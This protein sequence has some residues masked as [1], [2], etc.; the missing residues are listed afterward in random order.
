MNRYAIALALPLLFPVGTA[1]ADR[2]AAGGVGIDSV[3]SPGELKVTPDMWFYDQMMRQYK[4][5]KMAVRAKA[6]Y[7]SEQRQRRLESMKW[8]GM[9]NSRPRAS[10]DPWH[11]DYSPSWTANPGYYPW[12]WNGVGPAGN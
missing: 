4:D 5:P 2:P 10:S 8:F 7:R 6:V 3:A 12:R 1:Y 9:S 11:S